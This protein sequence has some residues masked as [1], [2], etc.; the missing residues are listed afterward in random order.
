MKSIWNVLNKTLVVEFYLQNAGFL[1]LVILFGF[2]FLRPEDHIALMRYVFASPFLLVLLWTIWGLY[3]LKI[4]WFVQKRLGL[5]S[6]SFLYN[7]VLINRV[8][9]WIL[10]FLAQVSIWLPVLMY[11]AFV[12]YYAW[13]FGQHVAVIATAIFLAIMPLTALGIYEYRLFRPNPDKRLNV[14]NTYFNQQFTKPY[15]SFFLLHL[16]KV[17]AVSF[18]LTKAFTVGTLIG[19]CLLYPTDDYDQ[20]LL[21][22]GALLVGVAHASMLLNLYQFEHL[23]LPILRNLPLIHSQRLG[24]YTLLFMLLLLPETVVLLRYLPVELSYGYALQWWAFAL[25]ICSIIFGRFLQKHY[26]VDDLLRHSFYF[27]IAGFFAIMFRTPIYII[28]IGN[29]II[30]IWLFVRFYYRGEYLVRD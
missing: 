25:S 10:L 5:P 19:L 4:L 3:H 16:F 14:V 13:Q 6:H 21:S 15:C 29:F 30:G 22:L 12:G 2:G 7:L 1:F 8:E 27:F 26:V 18:F 23:Q 28:T 9:R 17:E 24:Q 20:R 11:A